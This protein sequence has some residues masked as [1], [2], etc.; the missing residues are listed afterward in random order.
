MSDHS[1]PCQLK[2]GTLE[3]MERQKRGKRGIMSLKMRSGGR[4]DKHF[5]MRQEI[6]LTNHDH[7]QGYISFSN[8]QLFWIAISQNKMLS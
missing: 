4:K 8:L 3:E 6:T 5:G 2:A 1:A 7:L